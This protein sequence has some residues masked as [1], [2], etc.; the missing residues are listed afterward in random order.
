MLL[1]RRKPVMNSFLVLYAHPKLPAPSPLLC[2]NVVPLIGGDMLRK[3]FPHVSCFCTLTRC[4][5]ITMRLLFL[6]ICI[7]MTDYGS[8]REQ[9]GH[10]RA[11]HGRRRAVW[12]LSKAHARRCRVG[13]ES[14]ACGGKS[15]VQG[16]IRKKLTRSSLVASCLLVVTCNAHV[17]IRCAGV[18]K[19][20]SPAKVAFCKR[21]LR[22]LLK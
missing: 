8:S 11:V 18:K 10:V 9:Q 12:C 19:K 15:A 2:A 14:G 22:A 16:A 17:S 1:L 7:S 3:R 4:R 13:G 6:Y 5:P 21:D 20:G